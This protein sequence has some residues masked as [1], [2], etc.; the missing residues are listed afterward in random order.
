MATK[1]VQE[2][3]PAMV[4]RVYSGK[5]GK[6]MCGC[7]GRY[8]YTP[9]RRAEGGTDRGYAVDDDE[10]SPAMVTRV[11]RLVQA[12]EDGLEVTESLEGIYAVDVGKRT[13]VVYVARVDAVLA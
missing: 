13:Y 9:E 7:A 12:N 1:N 5:A 2:L 3:T 10:V 11:L 8:Y 6:C 4:L